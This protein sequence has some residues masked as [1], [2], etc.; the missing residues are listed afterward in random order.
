MD[1]IVFYEFDFIE[2]C[3]IV[4]YRKEREAD[5]SIIQGRVCEERSNLMLLALRL[6]TQ[7][8]QSKNA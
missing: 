5:A 2:M 6:Q 7:K 8:P 4:F 1:G 3:S